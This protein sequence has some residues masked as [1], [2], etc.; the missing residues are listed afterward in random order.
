MCYTNP[1]F[2]CIY[3]S[4]PAVRRHNPFLQKGIYMYS[5]VKTA[6]IQGMESV[7]VG[8][9]A[10]V[11]EG[12]PV[13]EM[14]GFLSSEVKEAKERVRTALKNSGYKLPVKRITINLSPANVRKSGSGFDLPIA[15]AVLA[16][17]GE[18]SQESLSG[19]LIL[20]EIGLRGNVT[21]IRGVLPIVAK[22]V[23]EGVKRCI[24][25]LENIEEAKLIPGINI[26]GVLHIKEA[27]AYLKGKE[28]QE[29]QPTAKERENSGIC[30]VDFSEINGQKSTKRACEVAVAGMHNM[31]MIG[32]PGSGKTMLAKRIPGILPPLTKEEQLELSKVYSVCGLLPKSGGL[33]VRRPFRSPH[34][35]VSP[36][37]LTGGGGIPKPGEIS[38]AH[39]GVLFLDE[40]PEFKKDT[41][42]ILRQP[43]EERQVRLVRQGGNYCY[44]AD[45]MLVAAMN[46][47]K[48]GYYPDR[49]RCGCTRESIRRYL[50]RI[51][52]PLLDRIDICVETFQ[53]PYEDLVSCGEN[54]SSEKSRERVM[55]A[56]ER[57]KK[58]FQGTEIL[59]NSRIPAGDMEKYCGL[60][61]EQ[62]KFMKKVYSSLNLTA[63]GYHKILKTARTIADLE[64]RGDILQRHLNEAVC[65]R[66]LDKKYWE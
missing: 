49:N 52:M 11:S 24:L 25:P 34:H 54:E 58:R 37:G 39:R 48:C 42:E 66:A 7:F 21:P 45:F 19:T 41:L 35:T 46:P 4:L 65:Y 56:L 30:K 53:I 28:Y 18:I 22:A 50:D 23:E 59:Y 47:C 33:M 14:V 20:G 27:V 51:S 60:K 6:S 5:I 1:I 63:R 15:L 31:L 32:P 44:P 3:V 36:A 12:L 13:F 9:E 26:W 16:A 40:L 10:D 29:P 55:D 8:V 64:G 17:L 61:E 43:M 2:F 62:K 38:L 57:Q